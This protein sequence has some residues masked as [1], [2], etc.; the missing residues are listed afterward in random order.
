MKTANEILKLLNNPL[1]ISESFVTTY[2]YNQALRDLLE[3]VAEMQRKAEA[4]AGGE[5]GK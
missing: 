4:A 2:T 3:I 5:E 1:L